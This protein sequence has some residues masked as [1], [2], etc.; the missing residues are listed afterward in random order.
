MTEARGARPF[1]FASGV[2]LA[3]L[4]W[5][6]LSPFLEPILW[7]AVLAYVLGPGHRWLLRRVRRANL[8][9]FLATALALLLV[10][11]PAVLLALALISQG[12]HLYTSASSY[13]AKHQVTSIADVIAMPGV[14]RY[15]DRVAGLLPL[16]A[17]DIRGWLQTNLKTIAGRVG[18]VASNLAVGILGFIAS[19]FIMLF[20]LFFLFR[21]GA[22]LWHRLVA[23][24]PLER[25]RTAFLIRRLGSVLQAVLA[26]TLLTAILQGA[27]GGI[28]FAVFGLPSPVVFG[29]MMAV[30][31]LLPIGGTA[32]VWLPAAI[33]LVVQGSVGRGFGLAAWGLLVVGLADNWFKPMI[34]SGRSDLN[35]LP[36]F[37][38]VLGGLAAFGFIGLFIGPLAIA[39]GITV[40]E[41]FTASPASETVPAPARRSD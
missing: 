2:L 15:T 20:T 8:A 19:F 25:A 7:A 36:I 29:A 17:E 31:S 34:I 23:A 9:A 26:G 24:I 21:D 6:I 18:G 13:L 12:S 5:R 32:F 28:G 22:G 1:L 41:T 27:L 16:T 30:L 39:L 40:W 35:T 10:V 3:Y 11:V 37:F 4:L 33:V 38:G 14:R